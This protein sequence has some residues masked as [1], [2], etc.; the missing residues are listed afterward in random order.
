M[1]VMLRDLKGSKGPLSTVATPELVAGIES[2]GASLGVDPNALA[3]VMLFETAGTMS[4]AIQNPTSKATGL[5]QFIAPT[6]KSLGTTLDALKA[7]SATEQL[8]YVEA[9]FKKF[10]KLKDVADVY[11]A[12]FWPKMIGQPWATIIAEKGDPVTGKVYDQNKG[13]DPTGR[14][15]FT[16]SDIVS[17]VVR[18]FNSSSALLSLPKA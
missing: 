15:Y 13:F 9:Y 18:I 8:K 6:A 3:A 14:G 11:S 10:G 12:V 17:P 7:M 16:K 1:T 2:L 5:I 4:P